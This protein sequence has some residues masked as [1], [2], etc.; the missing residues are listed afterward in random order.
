VH[1]AGRFVVTLDTT[2]KGLLSYQRETARIQ[3]FPDVFLG[4]QPVH[5]ILIPE[6]SQ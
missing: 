4:A 1:T 6:N 2:V 5:W 3:T